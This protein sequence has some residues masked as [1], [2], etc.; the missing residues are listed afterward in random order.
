MTELA[1]YAAPLDE[2]PLAADVDISVVGP[3]RGYVEQVHRLRA[4]EAGG[5]RAA[6]AGRS[7]DGAPII[8]VEL[9]PADASQAV[10]LLGG[11]HP[12]EWIGV[13]VAIATLE[14]LLASAPSVRVIAFPMINVDGYRRVESDL[15]AGRRRFV[16][17]NR[18]AVDLNR[19]WPVHFRA[20]RGPTSFIAGWNHGGPHPM[21]EPEV[22]AVVARL[23]AVAARADVTRALSLH[24]I[25]RK[26]LFPYGGRWAAPVNADELRHHARA[27]AAALDYTITQSS[28][29]VPG[30]FAYGMELD[31]LADRYGADALLVE[32]TRGGAGL[33]RPSSLLH[34]FRWFNPPNPTREI[35]ALAGAA[36][37]FLVPGGALDRRVVDQGRT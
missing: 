12:L 19:N 31:T 10:V 5:A 20:R 18:H 1:E 23:D 6:I 16:R 7:V 2:P 14:R 25:G 11:I 21:S 8:A 32:C 34:P 4:L 13:E 36:A 17:G 9:G 33:R 27:F 28:R 37:A 3:Y 30:A 22:A 15:R 26:V 35:A 29:W 24:S